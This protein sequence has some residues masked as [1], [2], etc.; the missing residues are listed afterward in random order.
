MG[1]PPYFRMNLNSA[2]DW[3]RSHPAHF[4]GFT[5]LHFVT[6]WFHWN[7]AFPPRSV[8]SASITMAAIVV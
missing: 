1:E 4:A 2:W 3:M 5:A 6:F 7:D 8:I